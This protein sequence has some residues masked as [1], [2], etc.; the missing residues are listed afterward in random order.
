MDPHSNFAKRISVFGA[1]GFIG[2]HYTRKSKF[3]TIKIPKE[4]NESESNEIL[5]LIG[6]TSNYNVYQNIF[7]DVET[8][9]IKLLSTLDSSRQKFPDLVINFASTWFVYGSGKI[10]FQENQV[11]KPRGFYSISKYSAELMLESYCKTFNIEYR[12]I[13]LGNVIGPGDK[14]ASSQKNAVQYLANRIRAGEDVDLYEDGNVLRD[15]IHVDDVVRG[16][17]LI[18]EKSDTNQVFNL[19]S[20]IGTRIGELLRDFKHI[21]QSESQIGSIDTPNFHR[22]VQS[23]NAILDISKIEKLGFKLEHKITERDFLE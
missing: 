7:L 8:N 6:T 2:S 21:T 17:D 19:A 13:R 12:I 10:P 14:K 20:G 11:C 3:E 15:F 1:T 22:L 23:Q 5:F 4:V 9:I 18:I 16:I